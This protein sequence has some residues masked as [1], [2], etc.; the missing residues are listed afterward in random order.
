VPA[1]FIVDDFYV[2]MHVLRDGKKAINELDAICHEDVS[3][4]LAQVLRRKVRI[5]TG[6]FQNLNQFKGLL[7]PPFSGVA[8]AFLSHKVIRWCTPFL[9]LLIFVANL[10]L[11]QAGWLYQLLFA[12]QLLL[13]ALILVD[14][15]FKKLNV[16]IK[17][18]RFITHFYSMNAALFLGWIKYL[19]GV[20][21]SVWTPTQ[22]F[23]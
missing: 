19:K 23:Q 9:L 5:S 8:F 12:G 1:N 21:T 11:L 22:R 20:K 17:L 2:S 15:L 7:W 13:L 6:N 16:H 18:F 14:F 10:L 4:I 3:D